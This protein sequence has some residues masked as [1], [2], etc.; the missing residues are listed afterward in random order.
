MFH[1]KKKVLPSCPNIL[2]PDQIP[3]F[4]IPPKLPSMLGK[5]GH[6]R[7]VLD[8][9]NSEMGYKTVPRVLLWS[10]NRHVIQVEDAEPE[11]EDPGE[12]PN[13]NFPVS[14]MGSPHLSESPHTRR[15]ESLFHEMC[16]THGSC[17][18]TLSPMDFTMGWRSSSS[19]EADLPHVSL[20]HMENDTTSSS[21]SSPFSSPLLT[22]NLAGNLVSHVYNKQRLFFQSMTGRAL[23]RANSL[24]TEETSSTDTSPNFPRKHGQMHLVPPPIF[25]LDFICC[26]ER[27]TKETEVMLSR[28]GLL[29]LSA[30]YMKELMRL[31]V[32]L[33]SAEN[34]YPVNQDPKTISCCVVLYLHPG[35]LQKQRST[36]IRRSRS[37][38]F[39][40][41]FFFEGVEKEKLNTSSLRVKVIN[42]GSGMRRD[43]LLGDIVL[44]LSDI[45]P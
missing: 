44:L 26:Q 8:K 13:P 37:P 22:R 17:E 21:E 3:K 15:R 40:E 39:N 28:G 35:K 32:K 38:I 12:N 20:G 24:S 9:T 42:R 27:L 2:T 10:A 31:R 4:F 16:E 36:V 18:K 19:S 14:I 30:E 6:A 45:V 25:H 43:L 5:S 34:L 33:V 7:A 11:T 41:D 23:D 29:H 1:H